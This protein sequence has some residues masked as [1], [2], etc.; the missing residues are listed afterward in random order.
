MNIREGASVK[1]NWKGPIKK[2]RLHMQ[3]R[4]GIV[5]SV[6]FL[7]RLGRIKERKDPKRNFQTPPLHFL[8]PFPSLLSIFLFQEPN[9]ELA[10]AYLMLLVFG[11]FFY[12][13]SL[14]FMKSGVEKET[15]ADSRILAWE[16]PWTEKPSRL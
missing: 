15:V 11:N 10:I 4:E 12:F 7:E 1:D 5:F 6:S 3:E 8:L 14:S 9:F 13:F 16:I 2:E